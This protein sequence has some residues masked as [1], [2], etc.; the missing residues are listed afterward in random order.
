MSTDTVRPLILCVDDE[1]EMLRFL[2]ESFARRGYDVLT[3]ASGQQAME[4]LRQAKRDCILW[5]IM[6]PHM[7]GYTLC[8][9]LQRQEPRATLPVNFA[10][11]LHRAPRRP[12]PCP[13]DGGA[14][15]V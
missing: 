9:H 5:D 1:A 14:R 12:V 11:G 10:S 2:K 6:M 4:T 13:L 15:L 8:G 7:L 3:A